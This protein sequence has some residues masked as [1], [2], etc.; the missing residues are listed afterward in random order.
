MVRGRKV[1]LLGGGEEDKENINGE[2]RLK[3]GG[4]GKGDGNGDQRLEEVNERLLWVRGR[5]D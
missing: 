2:R 1:W 5:R 3:E 4:G